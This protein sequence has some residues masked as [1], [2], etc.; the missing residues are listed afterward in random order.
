MNRKKK[1]FSIPKI[2]LKFKE[3]EVN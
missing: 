1:S 2:N 3:D